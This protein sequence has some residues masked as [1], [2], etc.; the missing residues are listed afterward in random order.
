MKEVVI[1]GA[2]SGIGAACARLFSEKGFKIHL[3]ARDEQKLRS[4]QATLKNTSVIH[5]CDLG[6]RENISSLISSLQSAKAQVSVL[7]NNAGVYKRSRFE[8]ESDALWDWHFAVNLWAPVALTRALWPQ[9]VAHKG[10]VVNVSST[11]GLRPIDETGA[12]SASKAALNNWTQTLALEAG[13]QG[14]RVNAVCPGLVDTPIH[15]FHK[16]ENQELRRIRGALNSLQPLGRVGEPED[17]AQAVYFAA[18]EAPWMTGALI[19]VDGGVSLTTRDP[20]F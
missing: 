7:V 3:V 6:K 10:A 11:L 17:I 2:S 4:V 16:S 19:P 9:L 15:S 5:V 8:T 20:V 12:Y 13:G 18:A 14:V 1:T